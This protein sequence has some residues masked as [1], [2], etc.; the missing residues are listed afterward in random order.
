MWK[1]RLPERIPV[2]MM[3]LNKFLALAGIASRRRC[4][5]LITAGLIS[6]NGQIM[7]QVGVSIDETKDRVEFRGKPV[8]IAEEF[9]YIILNKPKGVLTTARDQFDRRTVMDLIPVTERVYPV[10]RLDSDTSGLLLVTNDGSLTNAMI[11]PKYKIPK[12][13]HVLLDKRLRPISK[14]TFEHGVELDGVKTARCKLAEIRIIDNASFVEVEIYEG[15][16]RQIRRMFQ[17]LG[18][19]VRQLERISFGPLGVSGLKRGEW[20]FLTRKE[21]AALKKYVVTIEDHS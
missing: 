13:Y 21:I 12:V 10:G 1:N 14:Y 11:H 3:R 2:Q 8:S 4:D 19:S 17:L 9:I 7:D 20:R 6:V 16:N 5:D 15:R 18:Y